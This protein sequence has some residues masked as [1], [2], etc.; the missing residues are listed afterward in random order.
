MSERRADRN[1][2]EQVVRLTAR[3]QEPLTLLARVAAVV[4]RS[5]PYDGAG[6]LL[7][8]PDSMLLTG[9][10]NEGVTRE[11]HLALIEAER[12][13]DDVSSFASLAAGDVDAAALGAA[14]DGDLGRSTRWR[15]IYEPA[16]YGA[17]R[18]LPLGR[19]GVGLRVPDSP[20]RRTVLRTRRGAPPRARVPARRGAA[21]EDPRRDAACEELGRAREARRSAADDEDL[22]CVARRRP[23]CRHDASRPGAVRPACGGAWA[24]TT[25][26][27][28]GAPL[29]KRRSPR[30][31]HLCP[32][33][34]RRRVDLEQKC[35]PRRAGV[36]GRGVGRGGGG[37]TSCRSRRGGGRTT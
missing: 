28:G 31:R 18:R 8:D 36:G 12:S 26:P 27:R 19:H 35:R 29:T 24:G 16:G 14:T 20:G 13:G 34:T 10:H 30:G 5:I 2:L 11:Q 21:L 32:R 4:R 25:P 33:S 1:L 17:A 15:A 7:V 37:P 3:A 22:P 23:C 6:W 9:V